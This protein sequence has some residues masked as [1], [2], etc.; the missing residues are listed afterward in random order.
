[1]KTNYKRIYLLAVWMMACV[2]SNAQTLRYKTGN[3][4][5]NAD[6][7]GNHRFVVTL[8]PI[9]IQLAFQYFIA[10]FTDKYSF[11]FW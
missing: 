8:S 9:I 7:L 6:S 10:Y 2:C 11:I 3:N 5:W 4:S 1:M